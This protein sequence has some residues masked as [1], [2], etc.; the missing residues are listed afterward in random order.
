M[1]K[2]ENIRHRTQTIM[3]L[4]GDPINKYANGGYSFNPF[5]SKVQRRRSSEDEESS[6]F[7][8]VRDSIRSSLRSMS[9]RSHDSSENEDYDYDDPRRDNEF[10]SYFKQ[11]VAPAIA[12]NRRDYDSERSWE[13]FASSRRGRGSVIG[14]IRS[15]ASKKNG[16]CC[17]ARACLCLLFTVL[18]IAGLGSSAYIYRN[19]LRDVP[20]IGYII[21]AFENLFDEK[22][23]SPTPVPQTYGPSTVSTLMPVID[24]SSPPTM[25]N[26]SEMPSRR[27]VSKTPTV[28]PSFKPS[29]RPSESPTK[30]IIIESKSPSVLPSLRP[31]REPTTSSPT[32]PLCDSNHFSGRKEHYRSIAEKYLYDPKFSDGTRYTEPINWLSTE[33]VDLCNVSDEL[34]L[35]KIIW[36]LVYYDLSS[37]YEDDFGNQMTT[38]DGYLVKGSHCNRYDDRLGYENRE[39]SVA[40]D[41]N[42]R[43]TELEIFGRDKNAG[44]LTSELQLLS[45]LQKLVI[46][47][48]PRVVGSIPPGLFLLQDLVHLDLTNLGLGGDLFP[49][50]FYA[51]NNDGNPPS[52][53]M[54]VL[55]LGS[56]ASLLKSWNDSDKSLS[57]EP[58]L[59]DIEG[60]TFSGIK[61]NDY[62]SQTFPSQEIASFNVLEDLMLDNCNLVGSLP[63]YFD[64]IVALKSF[65]I[66][67]NTIEGN[68]PLFPPTIEVISLKSN[69]LSGSIPDLMSTYEQL[70][71]L[72]LGNNPLSGKIPSSLGTL[73]HLK[74]LQLSK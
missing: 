36:A 9:S 10:Y 68:I 18:V 33:I 64:N 11:A 47:N 63:S 16:S 55:R 70:K 3:G 30:Q 8:S 19:E 58:A 48:S 12:Q 72:E 29:F 50:T 26:I 43:I 1:T 23:S 31:S 21:K 51:I 7:S 38:L 62:N 17:R 25:P 41:V 2:K 22:T 60:N 5:A 24:T 20:V 44:Q 67:G 53:R 37:Q 46:I 6:V 71:V 61:M 27:P 54:K 15:R 45:K 56:D 34:L 65:S 39:W 57:K 69:H 14:S 4:K 73:L 74:S 35:E 32:T 42:G 49:Q 13:S 28:R 59:H 52:S 66:W 40:C